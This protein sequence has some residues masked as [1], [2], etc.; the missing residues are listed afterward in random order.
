MG[1]WGGCPTR[2]KEGERAV[3]DLPQSTSLSLERCHLQ[4]AQVF[5][6]Q[7]KHTS[8]DFQ[9]CAIFLLFPSC[10]LNF[11]ERWFSSEPE[12]KISQAGTGPK[13]CL[14]RCESRN[15]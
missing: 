14:W 11:A 12:C 7:P 3:G 2:R 10:W 6:P 9:R 1:L 15:F 5:L 13:P 8:P 4:R